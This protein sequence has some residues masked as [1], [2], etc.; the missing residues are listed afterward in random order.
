MK[1]EHPGHWRQ[2][3]GVNAGWNNALSEWGKL[4]VGVYPDH[5]SCQTFLLEPRLP[6]RYTR[7]I[8]V[9]LSLYRLSSGR[10]RFDK[11]NSLWPVQDGRPTAQPA[12]PIS[13]YR[14]SG[15]PNARLATVAP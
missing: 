12:K 7:C 8:L 3:C 14:R 9:D 5:T 4:P 11:Q 6:L 1:Q 10:E 13:C 15:G 2:N